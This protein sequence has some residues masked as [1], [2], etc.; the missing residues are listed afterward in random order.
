[1]K[2]KPTAVE[3]DWRHLPSRKRTRSVTR[4][5]REWRAFVRPIEKALGLSVTA[6]DPSVSFRSRSGDR[7]IQLPAWFVAKLNDAL[8]RRAARKKA[9]RK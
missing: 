5:V 1:M 6:W 4:Y 9:G 7:T 2:T 8:P 3:R